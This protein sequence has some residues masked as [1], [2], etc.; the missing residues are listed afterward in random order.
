MKHFTLA[1][2]RVKQVHGICASRLLAHTVLALR[3]SG[4]QIEF[5]SLGISI[6]LQVMSTLQGTVGAM[7]ATSL[8]TPLSPPAHM[9]VDGETPERVQGGQYPVP[10]THRGDI[11]PTMPTRPFKDETSNYPRP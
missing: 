5:L 10:S 3:D 9:L 1:Q 2:V 7:D 4:I 11:Y 6:S 8:P